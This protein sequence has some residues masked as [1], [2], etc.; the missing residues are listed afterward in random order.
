MN[1]RASMRNYFLFFLIPCYYFTLYSEDVLT[2]KYEEFGKFKI[3]LTE[4]KTPYEQTSMEKAEEEIDAEIDFQTSRCKQETLLQYAELLN[5]FSKVEG[6][7]LLKN[8]RNATS[9]NIPQIEKNAKQK[10]FELSKFPKLEILNPDPNDT[11]LSEVLKE[12]M[13]TWN[14]RVY[15][16]SNFYHKHSLIWLG[17]EKEFSEEI[18]RIVY[19]DILPKRKLSLLKK[20]H[21]DLN[22]SNQSLYFQFLYS[23]TNPFS[24]I[25]LLEENENTKMVLIGFLSQLAREDSVSSENKLKTKQLK[26]CLE[27]LPGDHPKI[28]ILMVYGFWQDYEIFIREIGSK[29]LKELNSTL[30][31][32]K[33]NIF[34]S[35]HF[36]GRLDAS[37]KSCQSVAK[38][39]TNYE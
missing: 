8:C 34:Q 35:H 5:R 1:K 30:Q 6:L 28:R 15:I 4:V 12:L 39:L 19:A 26:E 32:L 25:T 18:N 7:I 24:A 37:L 33:K 29:D 9:K 21:D 31:F 23:Q 10:L 3:P 20:I 38:F 22:S 27:R 13:I 36:L 17:E 11:N 16:Y 14:E 2:K